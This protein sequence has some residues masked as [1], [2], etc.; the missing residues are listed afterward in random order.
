[1]V[2]EGERGSLPGASS[3]FCTAAG[4]PPHSEEARAGPLQQ[5]QPGRAEKG[6]A[7]RDG[8]TRRKKAMQDDMEECPVLADLHLFVQQRLAKLPE[9]M[10]ESYRQNID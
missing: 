3:R 2:S 8:G 10:Q 5:G 6:R 1:M 7:G 4:P 9:K